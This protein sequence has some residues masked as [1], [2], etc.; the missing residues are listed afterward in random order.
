[1]AL[2]VPSS[3]LFFGGF[4]GLF[5]ALYHWLFGPGWLA[6]TVLGASLLSLAA[7]VGLY[8]SARRH[9]DDHHQGQLA[10]SDVRELFLDER[11]K[12]ALPPGN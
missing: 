12:K 7:S 5:V 10:R 6:G 8:H 2:H 9:R 11:P 3:V 4:I 1:M